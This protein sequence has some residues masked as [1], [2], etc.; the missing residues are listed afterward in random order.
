MINFQN[1]SVIEVVDRIEQGKILKNEPVE[2]KAMLIRWLKQAW[3]SERAIESA[4]IAFAD[5]ER[6]VSNE[7]ISPRICGYSFDKE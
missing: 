2:S 1:F 5:C 7:K 6:A 3:Y 4:R